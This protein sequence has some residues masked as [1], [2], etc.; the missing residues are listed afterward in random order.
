MQMRIGGRDVTGADDRWM[1]VINPAT[2]DVIDHV[3]EGTLY[4]VD[5]AVREAD[6]AFPEWANRTARE[7]GSILLRGALLVRERH[8]DISRLL[9]MEQGKP[10][11]ESIDEVR[12]L[13]MSSNI[14]RK[15]HPISP[16]STSGSA[17]RAMQ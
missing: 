1:A 14:S 8:R 4:E 12:G 5:D 10:L 16:A 13:Q 6:A 2:G 9:T 17:G 15:S 7:R 3:P 11:R